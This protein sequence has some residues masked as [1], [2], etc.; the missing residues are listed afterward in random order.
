MKTRTDWEERN[1][2]DIGETLIGLTYSPSQVGTNGTLVLRSSNIQNGVLDLR[3]TVRVTANVPAKIRVK[4]SDI[5]ICVRNGSRSL[6]G[7]SLL[8]DQR[9]EGETF[10][11]FMAVFRSPLNEY[12]SFF[13][14]SDGFK[15]QVDEHLGATINQITNRSLKSFRVLIPPAA[16][17]AKVTSALSDVSELVRQ[18][19]TVVSKKRA[20]KLGMMQ[21]LLTGKTRLP[22]FSQEWASGPIGE[23]YTRQT[24]LVDPRK[25]R[26]TVFQ[27]FSLPAFDGG[28]SPVLESGLHIDSIKFS[29]P[30]D[31]ILISKL[32][33][34]IPRIWA[35]ADISQNAIASTEFVVAVPNEEVDRS[36]LTYLFQSP[37]IASQM[38]LLA[39]GT[40][41]SHARI[42]PNQVAKL[43]TRWPAPSEQ[44]AIGRLLADSDAEIEAIERRLARVRDV[45]LGM[46]QALL[47]GRTRLARSEVAA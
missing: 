35:P 22:G 44:V 1:L 16:D 13:F 4:R 30:P 40:T 42:H 2:G 24:N 9:V 27:H 19:E 17:R 34:R 23:L 36:F 47:T 15:R 31:A 46:M 14:Q 10:G 29:V 45:K 21:Q 12:L 33:P 43:M 39:V 20:I 26:A 38:K 7:K 37:A 18:L 3:D 11:A 8:L 25:L 41:G 32:N 5:L 28:Q 6:I